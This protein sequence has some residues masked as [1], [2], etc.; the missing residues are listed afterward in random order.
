MTY[1]RI[2]I[3]TSGDGT[4]KYQVQKGILKM[5]D[6]WIRRS[7]IYWSDYC[8]A[9]S[10]E[11]ALYLINLFKESDK[12]RQNKQITSIEYKIID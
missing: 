9:F 3:N 7:Y 6:G 8:P 11:G 1:Y 4:K 2:K 10:E 12:K 5:T